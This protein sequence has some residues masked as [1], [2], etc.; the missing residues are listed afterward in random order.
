M[1]EWKETDKRKNVPDDLRRVHGVNLSP[2]VP[3]NGLLS[4]RRC[5]CINPHNYLIY[6]DHYYKL[7]S[8]QTTR[9]TP[10]VQSST[11]SSRL[12]YVMLRKCVTHSESD[13]A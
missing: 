3:L 12:D 2:I 9:T 11:T 5:Q 7:P 1:N 8:D 4:L 13:F 10:Q 6:I